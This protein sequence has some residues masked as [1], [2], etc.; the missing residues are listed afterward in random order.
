MDNTKKEKLKVLVEVS[1]KNYNKGQVVSAFE[2][3]AVITKESESRLRQ[4]DE[5]SI[6][7]R[8]S[9]CETPKIEADYHSKSIGEG[10]IKTNIEIDI[11]GK[12]FDA[13]KNQLID[14]IAAG[15]KLTKA[16]AGRTIDKTVEDLLSLKAEKSCDANCA[17]A[18]S[19]YTTKI[20]ETAK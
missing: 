11:K 12:T 10:E 7:V 15:A 5:D 16:D 13:T 9:D 4:K 17:N 14:A 8:A 2:A 18:N 1:G 20:T 19:Y 3:N 6:T